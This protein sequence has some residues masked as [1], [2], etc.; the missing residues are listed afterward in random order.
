MPEETSNDKQQSDSKNSKPQLPYSWLVAH[1]SNPPLVSPACLTFIEPRDQP[2]I[3]SVNP[4]KF[5]ISYE[6]P[7][8]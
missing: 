3:Q 1:G 6:Q 2:T 4:T 5:L 7:T 8:S